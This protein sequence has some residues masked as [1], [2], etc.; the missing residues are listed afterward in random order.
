MLFLPMHNE[1]MINWIM[2]FHVLG[3]GYMH[4]RCGTRTDFFGFFGATPMPGFTWLKQKIRLVIGVI[5]FWFI[6]PRE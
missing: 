2:N 4:H 3:V 6:R 1:A 5:L